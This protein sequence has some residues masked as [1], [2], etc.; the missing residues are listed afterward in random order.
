MTVSQTT[1]QEEIR[2]WWD[3]PPEDSV[4]VMKPRIFMKQLY[5]MIIR[6]GFCL[7]S[8]GCLAEEDGKPLAY[9]HYQQ[10]C[11][12]CHGADFRGGNSGSLSDGKWLYG[13]RVQEHVNNTKNGL[14]SVGMPAYVGILSDREI[15]DIIE[16]CISLEGTLGLPKH[17]L[18]TEIRTLD[19]VLKVEE[20]V[21]A[22]S[23][24]KTPWAIDFYSPDKFLLTE[25]DGR[26][27]VFENGQLHPQ[28]VQGV[29]EVIAAGQGGMLDV[30]MD[31]RVGE[32]GWVYL[33][34]SHLL[35]SDPAGPAMTRIVRGKVVEGHWKEEQV[36]F[37]APHETYD[38]T[39]H[40]YGCRIAFDSQGHLYFT[41]G[42]RGRGDKAQD[43]SQPNGKVHRIWPDGTIPDDNPFLDRK[44]ALPSIYSYGH[45]NP[46]GLAVQ[47][48]SDTVWVTEHGPMGGDE[49][50]LV[51][52]GGNYGWP[53]VSFGRNYNGT[54][55]TT[56][57]YGEGFEPPVWYWRPS[58]AV[59]GLV[60]C[61]G[62]M[63]PYW[64]GHLLSG[65]LRNQDVRRLEIANQRV[66][67]EEI[68]FQSH[69]R[70]RDVAVAPD[71]SIHL[72]LNQPDRVVRLSY[73]QD[74]PY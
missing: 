72:V 70:V 48:G 43:L 67:H 59:C 49:L 28:A 21:P 1:F 33:S 62:G 37:A 41:I 42:D 34:Y 50:N 40:H 30:T 8:I 17:E 61:T 3:Y 31:P 71:G 29:P 19:Y 24:L 11:A 26:L 14:V 58:T 73:L 64:Q 16:Y 22:S 10:Y 6:T 27:R 56:Q 46:Q 13:S 25:R 39:R 7:T 53:V 32:N 4:A 54:V 60:V 9:R 12:S 35:G 45:R 52:K 51:Q 44:E 57:R 47:P 20:I 15:R 74:T 66:I 23:G 65:N 36:L 38:T 5:S 68:I 69:G 2:M 55:L 63:F 18:P